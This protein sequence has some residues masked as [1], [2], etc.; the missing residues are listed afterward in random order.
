MGFQKLGTQHKR[1]KKK[2]N[3]D[4]E[5]PNKGHGVDR[6]KQVMEEISQLAVGKHFLESNGKLKIVT[7]VRETEN[8]CIGHQRNRE[9]A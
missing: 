3:D 1:G 4:G 2:P 7:Q 5:F 6:Q 8:I 9:T